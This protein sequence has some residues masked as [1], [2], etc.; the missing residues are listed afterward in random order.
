MATR[1]ASAERAERVSGLRYRGSVPGCRW[2][3]LG[4]AT[5]DIRRPAGRC[6]C[7]MMPLSLMAMTFHS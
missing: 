6:D 7:I 2:V 1:M 5:D 4:N 3:L